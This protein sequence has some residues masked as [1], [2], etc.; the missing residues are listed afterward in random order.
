MKPFLDVAGSGAGRSGAITLNLST[1]WQRPAL[2]LLALA[3][4][5][6]YSSRVL[7]AYLASRAANG[8]DRVQFERA[9]SLSPENSEY[10]HRLGRYLALVAQDLPAGMSEFRAAATLN[11]HVAA[12]WLDL[13]RAHQFLGDR[14]QQKQALDRAVVADPRT[15]EVAWE[16]ANFYLVQGDVEP[17]LRQFR[18]VVENDRERALSALRLSWRATGNLQP[19]FDHV[20]PPRP[21]AH[22][23][24]LYLLLVDDKT[25]A[26]AEV[27]RH[28]IALRQPFDTRLALP[29]LQ[30]LLDRREVDQARG[31]WEDLLD[32]DEKLHPY[33]RQDD[34]ITNGSFEEDILNGGFDW[35]YTPVSNLTVTVD[36]TEFRSGLRSLAL[37]FDKQSG[38]DPGIQQLVPLEANTEYEFTAYVRARDLEGAIGPRFAITDAYDNHTYALTEEVTGS[39]AWR[40]TSAEFR[41][42]PDARL[43]VVRLVRVPRHTLLRGTLWIDDISLKKK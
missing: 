19:I 40:R 34:L 11:P 9:V 20:L 39:T 24:L 38:L 43:A 26:A 2:V 8:S 22:A 1:T 13:A 15:P 41:T 31:V 18:V 30:F 25:A 10:R 6:A 14:Q 7:R 29:Y 16:A 33:R 5:T 12:Y 3:L 28:L 23:Q 37:A 36:S 27:W 21:E 4:T 17:A 32:L 42:R 35:R